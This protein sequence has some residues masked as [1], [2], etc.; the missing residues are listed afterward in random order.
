MENLFSNFAGADLDRLI[1]CIKAAKS[2]GLTLDKY[3]QAGVNQS[4]GNVWLWSE[5]WAGC[6]YCSIGFDV[7]W[8]HSCPECGT[9]T[10]FD[11]Y[12]ELE[13]FV[14]DHDGLCESCQESEKG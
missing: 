11:T 7:A 9:E 13:S 1:E 2:A 10:D 5:D 8:S 12:R 3:T 4:S 6:V 14:S